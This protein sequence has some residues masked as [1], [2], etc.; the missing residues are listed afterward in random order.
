[1]HAAPWVARRVRGV[2][3]GDGLGPKRP[4]LLPL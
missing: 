4:E 3:S 1:V 2:S